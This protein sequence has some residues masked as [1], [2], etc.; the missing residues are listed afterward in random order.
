MN[1]RLATF[2]CFSLAACSPSP[3]DEPKDMGS[4]AIDVPEDQPVFMGY[5]DG[6][7]MIA[8][9][10]TTCRDR[11]EFLC[12]GEELVAQDGPPCGEPF[13]VDIY[14][15]RLEAEPKDVGGVEQI[16]IEYDVVNYGTMTASGVEC[17]L[18]VN[19]DNQPQGSTST[20][21]YGDNVQPNV[22]I[23]LSSDYPTGIGTGMPVTIRYSCS[24]ANESPMA[25]EYGNS[26]TVRFEL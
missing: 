19:I 13:E 23:P 14:V 9:G 16:E 21:T 4:D 1:L 8:D 3:G 22:V 15:S 5:M 25:Q 10:E 24:A 6:G 18:N 7:E 26:R 12:S 17:M 20:E 2:I 11:V